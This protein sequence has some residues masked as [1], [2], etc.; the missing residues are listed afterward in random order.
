MIRHFFAVIGEIEPK[1]IIR[2]AD[3]HLQANDMTKPGH[4]PLHAHMSNRIEGR[5]KI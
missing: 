1:E 4:E 3:F 5:E 2:E